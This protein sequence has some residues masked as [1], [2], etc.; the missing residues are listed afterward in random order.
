MASVRRM[1]G[2]VSA[3]ASAGMALW[4]V[5]GVST[6]AQA[7]PV[8][9]PL[10][11]ANCTVVEDATLSGTSKWVE[12]YPR[13]SFEGAL[14]DNTPEGSCVKI[15]LDEDLWAMT[16]G[17]YPA[18]DSDGEKVGTMVI[19]A[20]GITFLFDH[21]FTSKH[22]NVTFFGEATVG[23]KTHYGAT[24]SGYTLKWDMPGKASTPVTIEVPSCPSCSQKD[25]IWGGK[26]AVITQDQ[27]NVVSGV[28]LGNVE[29]AALT[30]ENITVVLSDT[31][32]AGQKCSHGYLVDMY[33]PQNQTLINCRDD[34][35][36]EAT[37]NN[38]TPGAS[39]RLQVY[40]EITDDK[41]PSFKDTGRITVNGAL[42]SEWIREAKWASALAGGAGV[43]PV[44]DNGSEKDHVIVPVPD[45]T[46]P[47]PAPGPGPVV[48]APVAPVPTPRETVS[49]PAPKPEPVPASAPAPAPELA[50]APQ[51]APAP[52]P[53]PAPKPVPVKESIPRPTVKPSPA[54][55][56]K[57]VSRTFQVDRYTP[58]TH[59][60]ARVVGRLDDDR[61]LTYREDKPLWGM[62]KW[63]IVTIQVPAD[64]TTAQVMQALNKA[65]GK[66]GDVRTTSRLG[67]IKRGQSVTMAWE[68]GRGATASAPWGPRG[69]VAQTFF[70]RS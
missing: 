44:T 1:T 36:I 48:P 11:T 49:V 25:R 30:G 59:A 70:A 2:V 35:Y 7:A 66:V 64:A 31:L 28:T 10:A 24:Y 33:A 38:L 37:I 41:Q 29:S 32:H 60:A 27:K 57:T 63:E 5:T 39:Y 12:G 6:A 53:A 58:R 26:F 68:L 45:P 46:T 69:K 65:T 13:V 34:S 47:A 14:P 19:E 43:V 40:A 67:S 9:E 22:T 52:A 56:P 51:P 18:L 62:S 8:V 4:G 50:P 54:S 17:S 61:R 21:E 42:K 16:Y 15:P 55:R 23:V 3:L 20:G